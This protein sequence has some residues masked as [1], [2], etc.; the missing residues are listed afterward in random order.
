MFLKVRSLFVN[1]IG[2][3]PINVPFCNIINGMPKKSIY[4]F[5]H[6]L[7]VRINTSIR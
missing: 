2:I 1:A 5:S 7:I 4:L 3:V 6:N